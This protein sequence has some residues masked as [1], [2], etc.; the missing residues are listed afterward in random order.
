MHSYRDYCF[1]ILIYSPLQ[2]SSKGVAMS[3]DKLIIALIKADI[4]SQ[5]ES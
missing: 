4:D 5:K 3:T 2:W 1:I